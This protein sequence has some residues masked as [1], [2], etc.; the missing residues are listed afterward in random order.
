MIAL[1]RFTT[2]QEPAMTSLFALNGILLFGLW[3]A[4]GLGHPG[5]NVGARRIAAWTVQAGALIACAGIVLPLSTPHGDLQAYTPS[6]LLAGA[7]VSGAGSTAQAL[8]GRRARVRSQL[9]AATLAAVLCSAYLAFTAVDHLHFFRDEQ[10]T[11][12]VSSSVAAEAGII[13]DYGYLLVRIG[14]D[15]ATATY[16]C[17]RNLALGNP[18]HEPFVPWPSYREGTSTQLARILSRQHTAAAKNR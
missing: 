15:N 8:I 7:L 11:G 14:R 5:R 2:S 17:P 9:D 12:Y 3:S 10:R 16:R 18:L 4:A 6:L 1:R 13:C